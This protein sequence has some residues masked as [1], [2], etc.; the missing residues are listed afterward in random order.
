MK[1]ANKAIKRE[2]FL[3]SILENIIAKL[4]EAK[5]FSKILRAHIQIELDEKSQEIT[6]FVAA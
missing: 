1:Q 3:L 6:T 2:K 5:I 4:E